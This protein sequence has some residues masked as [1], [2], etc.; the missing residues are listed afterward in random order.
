VAVSRRKPYNPFAD[1]SFEVVADNML[2]AYSERVM[3]SAMLVGALAEHDDSGEWQ[4]IIDDAERMIQDSYASGNVSILDRTLRGLEDVFSN[5]AR[6]H[7][8][9]PKT[10]ERIE[11]EQ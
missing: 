7:G 8:R 5:I 10:G 3:F 11:V 9:D 2:L 4:R 6:N 1:A